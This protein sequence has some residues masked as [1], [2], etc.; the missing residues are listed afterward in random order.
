MNFYETI[1]LTWNIIIQEVNGIKKYSTHLSSDYN[2]K[3]ILH[4]YD[5]SR[6]NSD[7]C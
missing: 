3:L 7:Y 1:V 4:S 2:N 5:N 6:I